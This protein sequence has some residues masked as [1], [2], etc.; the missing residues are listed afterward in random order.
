MNNSISGKVIIIT[1]ASSG[2]GFATAKLLAKEGA[3]LSLG[4]RRKEKLDELVAEIVS[5]GGTATAFATDVSKRKDVE[6]LVEHTLKTF[7][8]IDVLF[9]NAGVMP[10][11]M[12]ESLLYDEWEQMI[13][14]N[15]KGVLYGIGA[16]L[17]HF[18]GQKS[19][20]FI[21]VSSVSG[22]IVAPSSA[23]YSGTKFAVRAISEGLRQEVKPY[24]IRT[25]IISPGV[26]ESELTH[27]ITDE[28]VKPFINDL[29]G[30]AI[31]AESI[32]RAVAYVISQPEDVDIGE[33]IIRPTAQ[34]M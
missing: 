33:M 32:A 28:K 27:T 10:I 6:S 22:H 29:S 13:D 31:S 11:S 19:G 2:I 9:N 23:V 26:T 24:N 16:V 21:N 15:I 34:P 14:I 3:I 7:G 4:A 18:I 30:M 12:L 17:S 8:K 1:G 25:S 20:H 5:E